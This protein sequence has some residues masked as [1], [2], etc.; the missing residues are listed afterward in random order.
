[1]KIADEELTRALIERARAFPGQEKEVWDYYRN[2]PA[3]LAELRAP[4]YEEKA[5]DHILGLAKVEDRKM[6]SEE[7][8]KPE[9]EEETAGKEAAPAG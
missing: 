2:N 5:V 3:A 4:I 7:L 9:D 8:M 6:T 1:V